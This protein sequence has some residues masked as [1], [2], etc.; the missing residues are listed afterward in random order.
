M[1]NI[2]AQERVRAYWNS[3]PCDSELSDRDRLSQDYFLDIERQPVSIAQ[4][5]ITGPADSEL[6]DRDRLSQDYFL[7]IER[8]RYELQPHIP[9][10]ISKIAWRG[11]R[12]LEIGTGVGTDAR[13]I[14][15]EGG[16]YT[17]INIDRGSTET[18]SQALRVF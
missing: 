16:V 11:K 2:L 8:R 15:G 3:R 17:G 10:I 12:V 4:L 18:T 1:D 13:N 14:I 6:S 5:R 9:E 7:D